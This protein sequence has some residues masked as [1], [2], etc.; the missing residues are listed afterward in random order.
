MVQTMPLYCVALKSLKNRARE[1]QGEVKSDDSRN[2]TQHLKKLYWTG[3]KV[4][5]GNCTSLLPPGW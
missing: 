4:Q 3:Y 5:L 1:G 2:L